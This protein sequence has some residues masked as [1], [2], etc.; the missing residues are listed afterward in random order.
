M[1]IYFERTVFDDDPDGLR[2]PENALV[3]RTQ[4]AF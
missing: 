3:F 2:K 1:T 4:V